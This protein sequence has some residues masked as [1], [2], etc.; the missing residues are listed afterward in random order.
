MP[1]LIACGRC[2][3]CDGGRGYEFCVR[4]VGGPRAVCLRPITLHG[5]LCGSDARKVPGITLVALT[6]CGECLV[7]LDAAQPLGYV[8]ITES[9]MART[10]DMQGIERLRMERTP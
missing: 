10:R 3:E 8:E 6:T 5:N 2:E 9:G 4:P 7:L 1:P